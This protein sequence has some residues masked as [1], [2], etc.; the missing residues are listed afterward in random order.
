L[1]AISLMRWPMALNISFVS[2][3]RDRSCSGSNI[4]TSILL[5][6]INVSSWA[7]RGFVY[8]SI[9]AADQPKVIV[10]DATDGV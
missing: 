6:L 7:N 8:Y 3:E 10:A 2:G 9:G 4:T 1:V 5:V